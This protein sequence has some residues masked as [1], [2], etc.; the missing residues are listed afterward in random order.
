MKIKVLMA[1]L[2]G[3]T[4][5]TAF[6]QKGELSNAN[7]EYSKYDVARTNYTLAKPFLVNAKTSIDKA[8][9]NAKTATMSQTFALKAAIYASLASKDTVT[10]TQVTEIATAT[11]AIAKA[12]EADT[13]KEYTKLIDHANIELAQI[14][15]DKG[16]KAYQNKSYDDAYKA[17]NAA[18][19]MMPE[20]TTFILY[21]GISA[22]NAKNYT[23][24]LENY[25]KLVTLP[26]SGKAKVYMDMPTLYLLNKDT[27][28]AVKIA[29][30]AVSKFPNN[31]DLRKTEIEVSLMAGQQNDLI[32]KI[33]A[34]IKNDPKNKTLY[35]YEGL[36]YSQI[37]DALGKDI[38]KAQKAAKAAAKPGVK[39]GPDAQVEKLE[40]S[41]NDNYNKAVEQYKKA[42]ELDPAYFEATLNIGYALIAPAVDLYNTA[43]Q[44]PASKQKEYDADMA[45]A[46]AQFDL[47]KP[48]LLKAV[49]LKPTS[50]DALIN[51]KSYYSGKNDMVH[52]N[53]TQ[54]QIDA[55]PKN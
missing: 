38:K 55:L 34:A 2:F 8:A 33:E 32:N 20:D 48:Y 17:F 19:I 3:L 31:A 49:E 46:G 50:V 45:K 39:Q 35:Y 36:T 23:A 44:L 10:A 16:V 1:A 27:A 41:K 47:A 26:Y 9:A 37:A 18:R 29:S 51:L 40:Q 5:V 14:Q 7:D 54:K 11:E 28:D 24:A 43:R 25:K 30:E 22:S 13:K 42:I 53:E 12:K 21:T 15:L 4:T 6:A 52:L